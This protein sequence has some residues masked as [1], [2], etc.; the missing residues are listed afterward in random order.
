MK[1][2]TTSKALWIYLL[3]ASI[4]AVGF[5]GVFFVMDI[6][7]GVRELSY[8]NRLSREGAV[9]T[10]VVLGRG[11]ID[12]LTS[13]TDGNLASDLWVKVQFDGPNDTPIQR[14]FGVT[15][16]S[17][18]RYSPGD[19]L[20]VTYLI[21]VPD[22]YHIWYSAEHIEALK[23][24]VRGDLVFW[25]IFGSI[26]GCFVAFMVL[27]LYFSNPRRDLEEVSF[28]VEP[29]KCPVCGSSV[30]AGSVRMPGWS[31]EGRRR[32]FFYRYPA[33][34]GD[35]WY[36]GLTYRELPAYHC[37]NCKTILFKYK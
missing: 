16:R 31:P 36:A 18:H 19:T 11:V 35:R 10:A 1:T 22:K 7:S 8:L 2:R 30:E 37:P 25:L 26:F 29:E 28:E 24:E 32:R 17:Y 6:S 5:Y 4:L 21:D 14:V 23:S 9:S 33:L 20:R 15:P 12:T 13:P 34:P 27:V 3:V